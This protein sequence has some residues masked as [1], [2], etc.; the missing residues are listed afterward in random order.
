[1]KVLMTAALCVGFLAGCSGEAT[2]EGTSA[3]ASGS[4]PS[5]EEI[6][7]ALQ[8]LYRDN[9]QDQIDQTA[10]LMGEEKARETVLSMAGISE[11]EQITVDSFA[12]EDIRELENGDV[13]AKA[14]YVVHWGEQDQSEKSQRVTLTKLQGKWKV[15][16]REDL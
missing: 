12:V 10:G 5:A 15:I 8:Q 2:G 1:M 14:V 16:E 9:L 4:K 6:K 11:L 13:T 7:L 3:S